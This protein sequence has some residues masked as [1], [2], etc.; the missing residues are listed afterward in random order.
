M[1]AE[2]ESAAGR[3]QQLVGLLSKPMP[4]WRDFSVE[5][6][7]ALLVT[8][9]NPY[10][11][12]V[13]MDCPEYFEALSAFDVVF[14]DGELL[15]SSAARQLGRSV[16]RQSFDGNSLA[17]Q[18]LSFC[19]EHRLRVALIGGMTGVAETAASLFREVFDVDVVMV[20]SGFFESS[21]QLRD[22]YQCVDEKQID[23]VICGMGAP[24]QDQ[25]LLGLKASGW[26]GL[27]FTCGGYLD[28]ASVSGVTYYPDWINRLNLRAPYRLLRE[29]RRL[30]RRYLVDY[31]HFFFADAQIRW[32]AI[33]N[34]PGNGS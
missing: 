28:Q 4:D 3:L 25:F 16:P 17:P 15:A 20:R 6:N 7:E 31:Q 33:K 10:S 12:R 26:K 22:C 8:F 11:V 14:P 18:V 29:P 21:T 5:L 19:R 13:M 1:S 32:K 2:R 34:P 24:R 9:V 27:G 23:V 30:W